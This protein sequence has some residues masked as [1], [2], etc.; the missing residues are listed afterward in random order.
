MTKQP[1]F[2]S[3]KITKQ[4]HSFSR[5]VI[6]QLVLQIDNAMYIKLEGYKKLLC[7]SV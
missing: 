3:W 5:R 1:N 7:F 4:V 6:N 2:S